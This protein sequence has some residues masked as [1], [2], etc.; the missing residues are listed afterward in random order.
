MHKTC[1]NF[2]FM[3]VPYWRFGNIFIVFEIPMVEHYKTLYNISIEC[4]LWKPSNGCFRG[5]NQYTFCCYLPECHH[6]VYIKINQFPNRI[7]LKNR[8]VG[9]VSQWGFEKRAKDRRS[10]P[11]TE[12]WNDEKPTMYSLHDQILVKFALTLKCFNQRRYNNRC[13]QGRREGGAG[14]ARALGLRTPKGARLGH[15]AT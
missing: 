9:Y 14:E 6:H 3:Y 7:Y 13:T 4:P 8:I 10:R 12:Q 2:D 11:T 1:R 5:P 15:R